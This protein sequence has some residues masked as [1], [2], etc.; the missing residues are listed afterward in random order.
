LILTVFPRIVA[1]AVA[2]VM[3]LLLLHSRDW[4]SV[5]RLL[6]S[7]VVASIVGLLSLALDFEYFQRSVY[8]N[9]ARLAG[10]LAWT[11]YFYASKRVHCVFQSHDREPVAQPK[12]QM[13]TDS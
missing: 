9:A 6:L 12:I 13:T 1:F 3:A 7:L 8:F 11:V 4:T 2:A 10:L 5:E